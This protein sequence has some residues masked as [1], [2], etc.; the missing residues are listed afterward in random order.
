[1]F[2]NTLS[3]TDTIKVTNS[4]EVD[5]AIPLDVRF[6]KENL[7]ELYA[8]P[9]SVCYPGMGVIINSLSSLY[10]LRKPEPGVEFT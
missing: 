10:I 3:S 7:D 9:V 8:T 4:F 6:V 1:L 2:V 5:S